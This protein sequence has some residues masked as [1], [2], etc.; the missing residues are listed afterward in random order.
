MLLE[1]AKRAF[2][3]ITG[4]GRPKPRAL[5]SLVRSRT[6]HLFHFKDDGRTPNNRLPLVV[7]RTPVALK[8]DFDP[9]AVFED[10]FAAHG[11]R[12]S[13]RNGMYPYLHFH[14]GTHEVLGIARGTV[15]AEFGGS[16]GKIL[17][18]KA[19]DVA[20]LPAGTGHRRLGASRDLLVVGA[21]PAAG[22]YDEPKPKDITHAK[23]VAAIARVKPPLEDPVYG[24][25]GALV[26]LW[27]RA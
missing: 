2:E 16:N 12:D 18:L 13:W 23:A 7:Y 21:Y 19:G 5:A 6:P 17:E 11:W 20:I 27:R 4:Y 25:K 8:R 26:Q 24:K 22:S 9:A 3:K 15:R 14:T 10:L 1:D